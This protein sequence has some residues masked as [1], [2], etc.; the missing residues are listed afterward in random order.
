MKRILF[1][2]VSLIFLASCGASASE[3]QTKAAKDLCSCM[4][5]AVMGD[6]DIDYYECELKIKEQYSGEIMADEGWTEALE[7]ECPEVASK[8]TE[9]E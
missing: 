2:G 5:E 7:N 8:M 1:V 9:N 4:D 3:E 6:F